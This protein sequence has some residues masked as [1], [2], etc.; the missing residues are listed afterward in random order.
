MNKSETKSQTAQALFSPVLVGLLLTL[1]LIFLCSVLIIS[2]KVPES[3]GSYLSMGSLFIG[4]TLASFM[5]AKKAEKSKLLYGF[6]SAAL[7]FVCL[8]ILSLCIMQIPIRLSSVGII[9]V[10][11]A[12][13]A[14]LGGLMGSG[15]RQ[16]K[17]KQKRKRK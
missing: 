16:T 4:S 17:S 14:L 15:L 13:S 9:A 6:F 11:L 7:F 5:A 10:L 12:I 1:G 3:F 8:L 2:E